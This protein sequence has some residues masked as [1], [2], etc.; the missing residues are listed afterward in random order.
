[1]SDQKLV[2]PLLDGF[3]MGEPM[4]SHDGVCCYPAKKE[5]SDDNDNRYI[6]KV[7]SIPASQKQL[8]ALLLTGACK[9]AA[10]AAAYFQELADETVQEARLLHQLSR[11][12]GFL[13]YED[14]QIVPME[15]N[16]LGYEVYL[17]GTYKCSLEK[18]LRTNTMSHLGAVNLGLDLCAALSICRRAGFLHTDLKPSNIFLSGEREYRIG[19]LGF[20]K[21]KSMKYTALPS[22]YRSR[23]TP[24]ELH[25]VMATLNPTVDIYAVGLILYQIYNNGQ[26]PFEIHAPN[27][28]LPSPAN[29]DYEMAEIILKACHPNPRYR[30]Q[31]PI[32]MGQALAN[33]M[34]RNTVNDVPIVPP[35]VEIPAAE[36]EEIEAEVPAGEEQRPADVPDQDYDET[37]PSEEIIAELPEGEMSEEFNA[38]LAQAD[39]LLTAEVP[40]PDQLAAADD[41]I[42]DAHPTEDGE[43]VQEDVPAAPE[44]TQ[45]LS[46]LLQNYGFNTAAG[47]E[48]AAEDE[49][50]REIITKEDDHA[51][52]GTPDRRRG[53]G[54]KIALLLILLL[55][56]AAG[57]GGFYYYTNYY[58]LPIDSMELS[59]AEDSILVELSTPVD[60]SLLTAVCTDTYG[61]TQSQPISGGSAVFTDLNA[62][63]QYTVTIEA[64]GFHQTSEKNT[65]SC[66]TA[67]QTQVIDFTA[68][69]GAEDGSVILNFT[70]DGPEAEDWM[71]EYSAA[72]EE[73]A[74]VSF[75]GHM[76]S[77]TGLTVDKLYSFELIPA[78]AESL[79]LVGSTTLD[80]TASR[81][82]L[83]ENL[84]IVS[85]TD[86]VMDIQ[87]SAPEEMTVESWAVR[88]Y[89]DSGYDQTITVTEAAAQFTGIDA[90]HA[91]TIE[92]TAEG[93]SQSA[94]TYL[95]ANATTITDITVTEDNGL[96]VAWTYNGNAP[97]GG[98]L[99]MY[100]VDGGTN[101][102]VITCTEAAATIKNPIPGAVYE[103]TVQTAAGS[104][105]FGGD[106]AYTCAQA[107]DFNAYSLTPDEIK[108]SLCQTPDKEDWTY[109]D[110]GEY[111][112]T[113][114]SGTQISMVVYPTVKFYR[115]SE[116]IELMFI[117]RDAEGNV[118]TDLMSRETVDWRSLWRSGYAY[119][120]IPAVPAEPG[121]YTVDLYF[122]GGF[123]T[124]KTFTITE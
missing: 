115:P 8:D 73:P 111:S 39:E 83:A 52:I 82:I 28:E 12:E 70:I 25:D 123:V 31:T 67:K 102:E 104:T 74:T 48:E 92:V 95:S 118:R 15:D 68:K 72:D 121:E 59:V 116:N 103:I 4:S 81:L 1:M 32:E 61:N 5:N 79:W 53:K 11:L 16:Q 41:V 106:T 47:D 55:L 65:G 124:S 84:K 117:I 20:A 24:P 18:Y 46:D 91:H 64:S 23:Y 66:A 2:S 88:C 107:A 37:L 56:A 26:I 27:E 114:T 97:E 49:M 35:V 34:Q 42:A 76:V 94:R 119:L 44:F 105:V 120:D 85:C 113:F 51:S 101:S 96:N 54:G 22:K 21:L 108:I 7:I 87:W 58:L 19:D 78:S 3:I 63:T 36:A 6:V 90:A 60:E 57:F 89:D 14:W 13:P 43:A 38:M 110:V 77:I 109:Q 99:L 69:T 71:I 93:M 80:Y 45:Q 9:D 30:W 98:W 62:D 29:A 86:G 75:T 112:S 122:G 100:S 17:L 33:Y 40:C 10:A 50:P